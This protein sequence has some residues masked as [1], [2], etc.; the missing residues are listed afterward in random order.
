M[1]TCFDGFES[2]QPW[3]D[4]AGSAGM[5]A[6]MPALLREAQPYLRLIVML[7]DP[8]ERYYSAYHYYRWGLETALAVLVDVVMC[9]CV[10]DVLGCFW[11]LLAFSWVGPEVLV[12]MPVCLR[13]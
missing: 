6:S 7:R 12:P 1:C 11:S 3:Q 10:C 9:V 2:D 13:C 5:N 8:V 4:W